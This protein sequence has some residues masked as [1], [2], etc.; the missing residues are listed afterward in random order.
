M[1]KELY[2]ARKTRNL[3]SQRFLSWADVSSVGPFVL[4]WK[5]VGL[6]FITG[7]GRSLRFPLLSPMPHSG[8][9]LLHISQYLL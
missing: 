7:T 1:L 3:Q 8:P 6:T 9:S 5:V 2:M 4:S